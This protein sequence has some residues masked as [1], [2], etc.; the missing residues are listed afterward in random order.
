MCRG[1]YCAVV[2]ERAS[3]KLHL[4]TDKLG[5]RPVYFWMSPDYIVFAT[6]LRILEAVSFCKKSL[7]L[8]GTVEMACF[9]YPLSDRTPYQ[10]IYTLHGGEVVSSGTAGLQRRRYWRWDD[11]PVASTVASNKTAPERFYQLFLDAVSVRQREQKVVAT[12]LS[13]GLDSRAVVAALKNTG[14][15]VFAANLGAPNSQ[16]QVFGQQIADKLEVHYSL[17]QFRPLVE[18]DPYGKAAVRDWL[19]S[20][21]YLARRPQRPHVA[22]SGDGGSFG[23]GHIYL[24]AD[25]VAAARRGDLQAA[26]TKFLLYNQIGLHA[27]LFKRP[28]AKALVDMF[29]NGVKAELESIHLADPGRIFYLL[30]MQNDQRRHMANHFENMDL[31]RIEFEM[32]FFDA[33]FIAEIVREPID[34][35]LRHVFYLEWLKCFPRSQGIMEVPWQAYPNH[36]PCPLPQPE[37]LTYQWDSKS[38][39]KQNKERRFAALSSA[40]DLLDAN[41]F[42]KKYLSYGNMRLFMLLMQWGKTDRS[43][44][45]HAPSVIHQYWSKTTPN[46]SSVG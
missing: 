42:S 10:D 44:L 29:N 33:D 39:P 4:M 1:T 20:A 45:I 5:V 27:K 30:V 15:E 9:G 40:R 18:G 11:L 34:S 23:L 13:G 25:I 22:W 6:A 8:Q 31:T 32:P 26:T 2:Y 43:Y 21:E 37:G 35:F 12:L 19:N 28:I 46:T 17:L 36:A 7:D 3:Q 24:N 38:S 14:I 16:D 41:G